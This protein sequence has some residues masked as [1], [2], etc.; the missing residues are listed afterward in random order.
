LDYRRGILGKGSFL[1]VTWT[2]NFRTSPVN[3]GVWVLENILGTPPPEPPPNV[4]PLE[5]TK[6]ESGKQLTLREQMTMHRTNQPCAGCHKIMDPIG[7]ALENLDA[8][9]H[10]RA[11]QGGDGGVPI[12]ARVKLFDGQEIEGPAGLRQALLR[13]SPQFVR[14][15][16][17][18]LMTY[19]TGRGMTYTD[20]PT[21]RTIARN[22]Q[23]DNNRFSAIVLEI[24]RSPQF[25]MRVKASS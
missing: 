4:P 17:E 23:R 24:V 6:G 14:M 3:R 20:M 1:S 13:Y 9:G 22:I 5:D 19:A 8:D 21:I 25:Q 10:W 7:F 11:K 12:D 16:T 18:K 15:V 2:Q